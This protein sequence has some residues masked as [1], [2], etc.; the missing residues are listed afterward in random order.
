MGAVTSGWTPSD[1]YA[2]AA[3]LNA[4]GVE[5][6]RPPEENET[7]G[8]YLAKLYG[9]V[10]DACSQIPAPTPVLDVPD[11]PRRVRFDDHLIDHDAAALLRGETLDPKQVGVSF[12]YRR[13]G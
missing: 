3:R 8:V 4:A 9:W 10:M 7:A 11:R 2:L 6:A 5:Q 1:F 12:T 13:G